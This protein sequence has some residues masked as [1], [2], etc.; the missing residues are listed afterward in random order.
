MGLPQKKAAAE[1]IEDKKEEA[2]MRRDENGV[3]KVANWFKNIFNVCGNSSCCGSSN[4]YYDKKSWNDLNGRITYVKPPEAAQTDPKRNT[5]RAKLNTFLD[6]GEKPAKNRNTE[7][8]SRRKRR[9]RRN[10]SSDE[11]E[12]V[13]S[14]N[15]SQSSSKQ[16]A[17]L[18]YKK[19][20]KKEKMPYSPER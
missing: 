3:D 12:K 20:F 18:I 9:K 6:E 4:P 11:E 17:N 14:D 8:P 15:R 10:L 1:P 16:K 5:E 19:Q 2:K 7:N 13:D